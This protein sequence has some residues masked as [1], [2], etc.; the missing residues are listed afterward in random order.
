MLQRSLVRAGVSLLRQVARLGLRSASIGQ[1]R[2]GAPA[3][4]PGGPTSGTTRLRRGAPAGRSVPP[5]W[6]R[7]QAARGCVP[8]EFR[9]CPWAPRWRSHFW[10]RFLGPF[11]GPPL[12]VCFG[13]GAIW[14]PQKWPPWG[15]FF[16]RPLGRKLG[17][18]TGQKKIATLGELRRR[19]SMFA[20]CRAGVPLPFGSRV[21]WRNA[22][23][24]P[25]RTLVGTGAQSH[26]ASSS[27]WMVPCEG[28]FA[29]PFSGHAQ[30]LGWCRGV[31]ARAWVPG[32]GVCVFDRV[33][34]SVTCNC[35]WGRPG[36]CYAACSVK[37]CRASC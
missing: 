3:A 26:L 6:E 11:L 13:A 4:K 15:W 10:V 24:C 21:G 36:G 22:Q 27:H 5:I 18:G 1:S 7:Q 31:P 34:G 29:A 33:L 30:D 35:R 20:A 8:G 28:A 25:C 19:G 2:R 14:R 16:G 9:L 17:Q 12:Y 32:G 23:G 37:C